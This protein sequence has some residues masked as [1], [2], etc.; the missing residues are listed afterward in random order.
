MQPFVIVLGAGQAGL[1]TGRHL[2]NAGITSVV[3]DRLPRVGD[4]WR[5]RYASLTLFTPRR[6]SALPGL[7]LAGDPDGYATRDE[8]AD[9][10][11]RYARHFALPVRV[12]ASVSRLIRSPD[13]SFH[14]ELATG[15]AFVASAVVVASGGFQMPVVPALAAR[16]A[17]GVQQLTPETYRRPS[18]V[19]KGPALVVGDG[20]SGRDIAIEL[21]PSMPVVLATGRPRRLLP[22]R[23]LG[24]STWRWLSALGLLGVSESSPIGRIMKRTDPF[25]DR[26][27]SLSDLRKAGVKVVPRLTGADGSHVRFADGTETTIGSAIWAVGYRDDR[28]WLAIPEAVDDQGRFL[29][30]SGIS[31]VEGLFFVGRPWQRNRASAL[32]LGA[33]ADAEFIVGRI[34]RRKATGTVSEKT[35]IAA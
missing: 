29:H 2:Q 30:E 15:E 9:Y 14:V 18:N 3:F 6:F 28:S 5:H 26:G 21:A 11:E 8:F 20:S 31:P 19:A 16:L 33:G 35:G 23:L 13:G 7:A 12:N 32:I 34:A 4:S 22:E 1:A 10:L 17:P 27:R 24:I 25:P